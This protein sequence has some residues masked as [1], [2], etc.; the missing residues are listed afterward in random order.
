MIICSAFLKKS[1]ASP[2][3]HS[4]L[5]QLKGSHGF[6]PDH[7]EFYQVL[8]E[9]LKSAAS[10]QYNGIM[11]YLTFLTSFLFLACSSTNPK[12]AAV[13]DA[14]KPAAV[15]ESFQGS[16]FITRLP[17]GFYHGPSELGIE[18]LTRKPAKTYLPLQYNSTKAWPLIVMLHGFSGTADT[19][20]TYLGLRFRVSLRGFVLLEPEGTVMPKGTIG[21]GGVDVGGDQF[22]NAT[23]AC[24]DFARTNV[25]DVGYV[26]ALIAKMQ[27][28]Y[29]I[30][31]TRI[32]I[33]GHS[34][35]GFLANRLTC[36]SGKS[37][38]GV[39]SLAGGTF[40]KVQDCREPTSVS[41]LHIQALDDKTILYQDAPNYAGGKE[42]VE[43]WLAR[44]KCSGAPVSQVRK[45]FVF[46]IPGLDT[47]EQNWSDC[48]T[49]K[50]VSLWTIDAF[51]HAGHN[52][53][54]PLFNLNFMDAV[55]DFLLSHHN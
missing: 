11:K 12:T 23:A 1:P 50:D 28:S 14:R 36:E 13:V 9:I 46:L 10:S 19:E 44:N 18:G 54:V 43:Q 51:K 20:D 35:G 40:E 38:A 17:S 34:N 37:F 33:I 7:L 30:D 16:S 29:N 6:C 26:L 47:S 55:L 53:H 5:S 32:Y 48:A 45:D 21:P 8:E 22:W 2:A 4:H 39:A 52:P 49:G 24:C 27:K 42:T 3:V 25:D 41:Y 15:S 31:S